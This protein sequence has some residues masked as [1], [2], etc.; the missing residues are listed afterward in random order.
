MLSSKAKSSSRLL[1]RSLQRSCRVASAATSS[2]TTGRWSSSSAPSLDSF[3]EMGYVDEDGLV[4]FDTIHEMQVRA[5]AVYKDNDLFG[6]YSPEEE[7]YVWQTYGDY[8]KNVN[9]CRTVL[10]DLGE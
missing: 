7:A 2:T 6:T 4:Q 10:K 9:I 3:R 5:C 1:G 8:A